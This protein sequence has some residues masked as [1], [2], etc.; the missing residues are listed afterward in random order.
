ME[1]KAVWLP[2]WLGYLAFYESE[3][4]DEITDLT[5]ARFHDEAEPLEVLAAYDDDGAMVGFAT[6]LMHRSTW[7]RTHYCYLEDLF[8]DPAKRGKGVARALIERVRDI[9]KQQ[10]CERVYWTTK[11]NNA[12]AR[13]LYD[14]VAVKSEF[15]QYRMAVRKV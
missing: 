10:G 4:A 12:V 8:V 1:E 5:W 6:Y 7:A 3:L 9:A 11:A 15:V 13:K 2:L 14:K